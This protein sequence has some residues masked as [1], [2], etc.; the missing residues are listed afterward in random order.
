MQNK[1]GI[2][3]ECLCR[4]L[5]GRQPDHDLAL[6]TSIG[7]NVP[8]WATARGKQSEEGDKS[9][10]AVEAGPAETISRLASVFF[11]TLFQCELP[12]HHKC[13]MTCVQNERATSTSTAATT[14]FATSLWAMTCGPR[15]MIH[16]T[17][18]HHCQASQLTTRQATR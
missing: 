17:N 5:G 1:M 13:R 18:L 10:E 14:W 16:S 8:Q 11:S 9:E 3:Q 4:R 2:R 12:P 6:P 15:N 7:S